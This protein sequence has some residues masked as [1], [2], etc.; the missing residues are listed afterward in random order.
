MLLITDRD[1]DNPTFNISDMKLVEQIENGEIEQKFVMIFSFSAKDVKYAYTSHEYYDTA[2]ECV[3]ILFKDEK[4]LQIF[5]HAHND[6]FK[7]PEKLITEIFKMKMLDTKWAEE[8]P[9]KYV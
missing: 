2:P 4:K 5:F 9:E 3:E 7:Y 8:N 1:L 6:V